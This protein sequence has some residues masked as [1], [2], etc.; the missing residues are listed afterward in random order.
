MNIGG[1]VYLTEKVSVSFVNALHSSS[2]I[3]DGKIIYMGQSAGA[4]ISSPEGIVYHAG[5]TDIFS[6]MALVQKIHHPDVALLPIGGRFTM[7]PK[8]AAM[9]CNDFLDV[10]VAIPMHYGTFPIIGNAPQEFVVR[11][12]E[13]DGV[14]LKPGEQYEFI[15]A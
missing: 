8:T 1:T 7:S 6:D 10:D 14:I 9:A 2:L 13:P 4:V 15:R 12:V 3:E 11:L 5:D